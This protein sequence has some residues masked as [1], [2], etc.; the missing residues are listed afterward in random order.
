MI[1]SDF[2]LRQEV[3]NSDTNDIIPISFNVRLVLQDKYYSL[4]GESEKCMI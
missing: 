3:D 2:L 1:L 4:E